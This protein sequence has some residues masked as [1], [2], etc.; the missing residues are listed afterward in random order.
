MRF[1][2][3]FNVAQQM[4]LRGN[5]CVHA[6]SVEFLHYLCFDRMCYIFRDTLLVVHML[7][8][9]SKY[10]DATNFFFRR[11]SMLINRLEFKRLIYSYRKPYLG[12]K[13]PICV[14]RNTYTYKNKLDGALDAITN[15]I[16]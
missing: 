13:Y 16:S 2:S 4:E 7:I 15:R 1:G 12:S 10:E 14:K 3:C 8:V 11:F 5:G 6:I 9:H